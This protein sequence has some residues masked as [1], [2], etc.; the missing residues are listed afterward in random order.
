MA[1]LT[2]QPTTRVQPK[3]DRPYAIIVGHPRSG[4]HLLEECLASHPKIHKR[5]ECVLRYR[6]WLEGENLSK[7]I[8]RKYIFNNLPRSVNIA[9][10]MYKELPLLETL[11]GPLAGFKLIHLLRDPA[12][13]ARS[14][15]QWKA[16]KAKYGEKARA[17]YKITETPPP[18]AKFS[19][20]SVRTLTRQV[21]KLQ[22]QHAALF[23]QHPAT[24]TVHYEEFTGSRE[25]NQLPDAFS[26]K[27]LKF[28]GL[29]PCPLFCDLRK[30]GS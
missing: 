12:D 11:C 13:V 20:A 8:S 18:N 10:V 4:T 28:I 7:T 17:H 23:A 19:A 1:V 9:I 3:F 21:K 27:I 30:T 6:Q 25:V 26:R 24:L 16:N 22:D 5:S 14:C 2:I 29:K 15:A